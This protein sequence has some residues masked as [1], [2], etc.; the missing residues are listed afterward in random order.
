MRM[1]DSPRPT[2]MG[3]EMDNER[4]RRRLEHHIERINAKL[5][6]TR[7]PARRKKLLQMKRALRSRWRDSF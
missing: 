2:V 7:N 5:E 4:N 3:G 1:P 6:S